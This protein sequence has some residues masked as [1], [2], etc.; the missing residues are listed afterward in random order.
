MSQPATIHV[1][2]PQTTFNDAPLPNNWRWARLRDICDVDKQLVEPS[3]PLAT[4]LPYISLEHVE[5]DTGRILRSAPEPIEDEGK[6]T[7]Y[8]FDERHV[9][10]GKLRPY[11]NKVALPSFRGRCTTE[12]VPLLPKS[13]TDRSFLAWV[14]RRKETVDAAMSQKTGS[15]MPRAD[16]DNL[17]SLRIALPPLS[18]QKRITAILKEQMAAVDRARAATEAQ[19]EAA[20]ALPAAYLREIFESSEAKKWQEKKIGEICAVTKLAGFE[21]TKYVKYI[22]DG[23]YIA[24]RAQNIRNEG[25]N[26]RNVVRIS[27][28]V[29]SVL[30]R[31]KLDKNDVVMTFIG[32]NIG[33]ATWIDDSD[34]FYCAPNIAKITPNPEFV[35]YRFLT[36]AI[37]SQPF[38]QQIQAINASTAQQSLSMRDIRNFTVPL[39][40]LYEQ[41]NIAANLLGHRLT[42]QIL[43][44]KLQEQFDAVYLLPATLLRRAF[45]G[46]L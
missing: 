16:I 36:L 28:E 30:H 29:A 46:N 32:A 31:S 13:H 27:K 6:S 8:F 9:L 2:V 3:S 12:L 39:P 1:E 5:S 44:E 17:L 41:R 37:Q 19:L 40:S 33:E 4:S 18:E 26:L 11:L 45:T 21:Y 35:D 7:T 38:Q 43:R 23:E 22:P 24:L 34:T 20:K 14:L 10:Y 25:L 15:R 42:V